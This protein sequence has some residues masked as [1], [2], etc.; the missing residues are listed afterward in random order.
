[1]SEIGQVKELNLS[2]QHYLQ[3]CR[4]GWCTVGVRLCL[5][6]VCSLGLDQLGTMSTA[7]WWTADFMRA[8]FAWRPTL[9]AATVHADCLVNL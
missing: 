4:Y 1:M 2:G 8:Q 9:Q 5:R 7:S 6:G 3:P